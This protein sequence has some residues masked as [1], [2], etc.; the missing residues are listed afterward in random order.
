MAPS[1]LIVA[2]SAA[3]WGEGNVTGELVGGSSSRTVAVVLLPF[4]SPLLYSFSEHNKPR[5][6]RSPLSSSTL[7]STVIATIPTHIPAVLV[8]AWMEEI[9]GPYYTFAKG[10]CKVRLPNSECRLRSSPT[11]HFGTS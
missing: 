4:R 7:F 9:A 10:G 8:G 1:V 11:Q 6:R 3:A 5:A 2:T